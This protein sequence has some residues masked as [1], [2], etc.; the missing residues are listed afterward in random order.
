MEIESERREADR[1]ALWRMCELRR[2]LS[3]R[4]FRKA[5][6]CLERSCSPGRLLCR[7][8]VGARDDH[9]A[10][11]SWNAFSFHRCASER[12]RDRINVQRKIPR[13]AEWPAYALHP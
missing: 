12:L 1:P 9:R 4:L 5:T 8:A 3:K 6:Q 11:E 13:R 2:G 10:L 7:R